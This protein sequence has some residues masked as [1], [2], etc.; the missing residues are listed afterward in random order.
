MNK[1]LKIGGLFLTVF[2]LCCGCDV[3]YSGTTRDIRHSGFTISGAEFECP[4]LLPSLKGYEGIK[5]L[6]S[7]HAITNDGTIYLLSLSQPYSNNY[8]CKI[9]DFSVK[10]E[11]VFDG[12]VIRGNNGKLYHLMA[13]GE[14]PAFSELTNRESDYVFY[15]TILGDNGVLKVITADS[16]SNLYYVLKSDGNI[17]NYVVEKGDGTAKILSTSI[18]YGKSSYGGNIVDFNYAGKS[19]STFVRTADKI[20]RMLPTNREQCSKYADVVCDY[21]MQLDNGLSNHMDHILGYNG[22]LLITTY[23]KEFTASA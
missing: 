9:A 10:A 12:K 20:F 5:Y 14:Y 23:G 18:A 11:A 21:Q 3:A 4:A 13:S 17:Y 8:N 2:F 1:F 7:S 15:K 16:G 22:S 6:T 19:T